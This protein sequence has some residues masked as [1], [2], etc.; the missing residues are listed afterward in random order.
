MGSV[1][2]SASGGRDYCKGDRSCHD[3][4]CVCKLIFVSAQVPGVGAGGYYL[5]KVYGGGGDGAEG[6]ND[7]QPDH[8]YLHPGLE[9]GI[10]DW[11]IQ[12][13]RWRRMW[14]SRLVMRRLDWK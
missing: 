4:S 9:P 2:A 10:Q 6:Y 7:Q 12:R 13:C 5:Y 8:G 14:M 11:W 1:N 3:G